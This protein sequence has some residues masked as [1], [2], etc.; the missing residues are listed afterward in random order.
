MK[1]KTILSIEIEKNGHLYTFNIPFGVP[2]GE[3]HD[4]AFEVAAEIIEMSKRSLE[5]A[6]EAKKRT[7]LDEAA[8][9]PGE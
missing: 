1:T 5:Q 7:D 2:Y 9:R 6:A 8:T 3:A 4:V